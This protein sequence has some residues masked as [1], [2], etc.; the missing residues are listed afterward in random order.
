MSESN[1]MN[2]EYC[3][4]QIDIEVA[5]KTVWSE[6][7]FYPFAV[8]ELAI[9]RL[10][11]L[12]LLR[13]QRQQEVPQ[14]KRCRK[15]EFCEA[16]DW[17]LTNDETIVCP[18]HLVRGGQFDGLV[19]AAQRRVCH[20]RHLPLTFQNR[21]LHDWIMLHKGMDMEEKAKQEEAKQEEQAGKIIAS[22][23]IAKAFS[24]IVCDALVQLDHGRVSTRLM[25]SARIAGLLDALF[26]NALSAKA[27][28]WIWRRARTY[29]PEK[30]VSKVVE[31][32]LDNAQKQLS[33]SGMG[34]FDFDTLV[35]GTKHLMRDE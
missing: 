11:A 21:S 28:H 24:K 27:R 26:W 35:W 12:Y 6:F 17:Y 23:M 1:N 31:I 25:P 4:K 29:R 32:A 15:C 10:Q 13:E 22:K 33:R 5:N 18:D 3:I 7:Y 2:D 20:H 30:L 16:S 34:Y 9:R 14:I 19:D 8:M